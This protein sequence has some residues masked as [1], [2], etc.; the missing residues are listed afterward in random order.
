MKKYLS[1]LFLVAFII[2]SVAFASWWNPF[3]WFK[4]AP[5]PVPVVEAPVPVVPVVIPSSVE[6]KKPEI[7]PAPKPVVKVIPKPVVKKVE[8]VTTQEEKNTWIEAINSRVASYQK[9]SDMLKSAVEKDQEDLKE[10]DVGRV[11]EYLSGFLFASSLTYKV[12][13]EEIVKGFDIKIKELNTA[14]ITIKDTNVLDTT[15]WNQNLKEF[16]SYLQDSLNL[17][18]ESKKKHDAD[19]KEGSEY[20]KLLVEQ[21]KISNKSYITQNQGNNNS[22]YASKKQLCMNTDADVRAEVSAS[23]GMSNENQIQGTVINRMNSMGCFSLPYPYQVPTAICN[24]WTYS[25][26][27]NRSGTCSSHGGVASFY[28]Y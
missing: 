4:K 22:E 5:I 3:T 20:L 6:E 19:L 27:L 18:V 13:L 23:G 7:K 21:K 10:L 2:P 14:V 24:D 12:S 9:Y 1:V 16:D 28:P 26:S 11:D 15:A 8:T 17:A 25:Y